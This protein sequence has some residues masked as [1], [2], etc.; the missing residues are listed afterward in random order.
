MAQV[1]WVV[2]TVALFGL[3]GGLTC[4]DFLLN[5]TAGEGCL[6]GRTFDFEID[7]NHE[8]GYMPEGSTL[9][10]LPVC[11]GVS[12]ATL[13]TK[14]AFAFLASDRAVFKNISDVSFPTGRII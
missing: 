1:L 11:Q 9:T 12:P 5:A 8:I 10:L 2:V 4:S 13:I 14:H 3:Q 6:S 7:V